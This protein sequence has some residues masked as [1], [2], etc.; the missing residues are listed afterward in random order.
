MELLLLLLRG[1]NIIT[2]GEEGREGGHV[3]C[4]SMGRDKL[5]CINGPIKS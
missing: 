3:Y 2:E 1:E 5:C 4:F